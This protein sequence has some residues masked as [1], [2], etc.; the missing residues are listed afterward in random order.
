MT[1]SN[2]PTAPSARHT[3]F[4]SA[5]ISGVELSNLWRL[6]LNNGSW[7]TTEEKEIASKPFAKKE[8]ASTQGPKAPASAAGPLE[9]NNLRNGKALSWIPPEGAMKVKYG[10]TEYWV[11]WKRGKRTENGWSITGYVYI[12]ANGKPQR[13]SKL[14]INANESLITRDGQLIAKLP[15]PNGASLFGTQK[16]N[17]TVSG[18]IYYQFHSLYDRLRTPEGR[19]FLTYKK[20]KTPVTLASADLFL[21]LVKN[22]KHVLAKNAQGAWLR[23]NLTKLMKAKDLGAVPLSVKLAIVSSGLDLKLFGLENPSG[24]GRTQA[25]DSID[26][27]VDAISIA[28][29]DLQRAVA[30]FLRP[31]FQNDRRI[32]ERE[33]GAA[34]AAFLA[35]MRNVRAD[36]PSTPIIDYL[37]NYL[38]RP[39]AA[40][41]FGMGADTG[42]ALD[43][44]LRRAVAA[45]TMGR[46]I[47][48][49][50]N[51]VR[52][53]IEGEIGPGNRANALVDAIFGLDL[54]NAGA[55]R[56]AITNDFADLLNE[57]RTRV[58]EN[59]N[60]NTLA[61]AL[62]MM[63]QNPF[64]SI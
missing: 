52:E 53:L 16:V 55:I 2:G 27:A 11:E 60:P 30:A 44:V 63:Q 6:A 23:E 14:A 50:R 12:I 7:K 40:T 3:A 4:K 36:N 62:S 32:T 25:A 54:F 15:G 57:N 43:V 45:V 28:N 58:G 61:G 10:S 31:Y 35:A 48:Q 34:Q 37:V 22:K 13:A 20:K 39:N 41:E 21:F 42:R 51:Q 24:K 47:T 46:D 29:L 56:G 59:F 1:I 18:K 17:E 8:A 9:K 33:E 5:S 19:R 49:Y 64:G 26:R 38:T